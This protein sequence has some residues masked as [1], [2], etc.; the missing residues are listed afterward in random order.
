MPDTISAVE[1]FLKSG[2]SAARPFA[3]FGEGAVSVAEHIAQNS[4]AE[5]A[6]G[7]GAAEGIS[8]EAAGTALA[9]VVGGTIGIVAILIV[10]AKNALDNW[11][12][13]LLIQLPGPFGAF[14]RRHHK[15]FSGIGV[16]D[17][18]IADTVVRHA[19]K[20]LRAH[21]NLVHTANV[22]TA[23]FYGPPAPNPH[24][25]ANVQN[26]HY[27]QQEILALQYEIEHIKQQVTVNHTTN[28][29]TQIINPQIWPEIH[30]LQSDVHHLQTA[31]THV[32]AELGNANARIG[33]VEHAFN[34]LSNELH[35]VRSVLAGWQDVE[36][37]I[38]RSI[39]TL[40]HEYNTVRNEQ[41]N[42]TRQIAQLSPLALLL[43]PGI[44]G[45]RNLRKL[46][47]NPC[48]CPRFM[49]IPNELGTALALLEWVENG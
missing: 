33:A 8:I 5:L 13:S 10:Y 3:N 43:Q 26:V 14:F 23:P 40:T 16:D 22:I 4:A 38:E 37:E 21:V 31:M 1:D 42:H 44:R 6:A 46:E 24:T 9:D 27:L 19:T 29:T 30:A 35:G 11:I 17:A 7:A 12:Q 25:T 20:L 47:D 39:S 45:L 34:N 28:T 2:E 15:V 49:N 48:Q 32:Y 36:R 18:P 41:H